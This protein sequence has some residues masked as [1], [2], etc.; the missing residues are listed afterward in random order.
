MSRALVILSA[1]STSGYAQKLATLGVNLDQPSAGLEV[2]VH[3]SLD[4]IT[5]LPDSVLDL[6][7]VRGSQRTPV[8]FQIEGTSNRI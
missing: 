8:P 5:H 2:P 6:V 1:I 4:P 7:E 3:V